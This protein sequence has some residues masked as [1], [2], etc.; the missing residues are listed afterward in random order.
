MTSAGSTTRGIT[1]E[2]QVISHDDPVLELINLAFCARRGLFVDD[3][4]SKTPAR[5]PATPPPPKG[6]ARPLTAAGMRLCGNQKAIPSRGEGREHTGHRRGSSR[7]TK[8]RSNAVL[9][10]PEGARPRSNGAAVVF[11][12]LPLVG[13]G[14][15]YT[16]QSALNKF[17]IKKGPDWVTGYWVTG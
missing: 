9:A 3:F 16:H 11:R 14:V 4:Y 13:G 5:A 2:L 7:A 15:P 8:Q 12:V 10:G 6:L 17:E 1:T